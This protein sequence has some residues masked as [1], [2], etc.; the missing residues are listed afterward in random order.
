[1]NIAHDVNVTTMPNQMYNN[2]NEASRSNLSDS[3][4]AYFDKKIKDMLV[5]VNIENDAYNGKRLINAE[6]KM[7]MDSD[8]IKECICS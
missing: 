5:Q 1:V 4:A 3:F 8:S 6:N 2:K 7:F